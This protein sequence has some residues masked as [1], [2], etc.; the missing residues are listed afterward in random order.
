MASVTKRGENYILRSSLGYNS[1]GKQIQKFFTWLPAPGMTEKQI[2]KELERQCVLFDEKCKSGRLLDGSIKF[3]EFS[4]YWL[5]EYADKQLRPSTVSSYRLMLRR[6]LPAI[7]HIKL[8]KLQPNH[9]MELYS[10]LQEGGIRGNRK[11][12]C[13]IDFRDYLKR[14]GLS[15]IA[16][17]ERAG[18]SIQSVY[19]VSKGDHIAEGTAQKV[20]AA[21]RVPVKRIFNPVKS[22]EKPLAGKTVLHHHRLIS[23]I[24]EKAVKWQILYANPCD[25][26]E[27]PK[28]E[29]KEA[30][31]LDEKQTVELLACLEREPLQYRAIINLFLYSGMRR[32][33][34]CGLEW[35][36]IDFDQNIIDINKSSLYLP[37]KGIFEDETKNFSSHRVIKLP[38]PIMDLLAEHKKEQNL[39]RLGLADRWVISN[40]LF[41]QWD[42]KPIHPDTITAWFTKFIKRYSLTPVSIHSLRHTNATLLIANGTDLRTVSKRLGHSNMTTTGNIYTHAIQTADER[43]AAALGDIL[44]PASRKTQAKN[45]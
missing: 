7:G 18:V 13:S 5:S 9:L 15:Q 20:A 30:R 11:Q 34:L 8:V 6:I 29:R 42:G 32:G 10:N 39:A 38:A 28:V 1:K 36:D 3:G 31:Y 27:V 35:D 33:E 21:L 44:S 17:S 41:T 23:S 43:A 14:Q 25:R 26:V 37:E 4:E 45:A 2:E 19:S 22:S 40:K 16:L 24:L 12:V